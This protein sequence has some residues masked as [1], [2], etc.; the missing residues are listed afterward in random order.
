MSKG[1]G[2][3]ERAIRELFDAHPDLAFITDELAEHCFPEAEAIERKHQVSVLRA[4][5]KVVAPDP[6]WRAWRI[7]GQGRGWVFVNLANVQSYTLG[8]IIADR[9]YIY[10]S[11]KRALR[12]AGIWVRRGPGIRA[13]LVKSPYGYIADRS[14]LAE[15]AVNGGD[16]VT[17]RKI[18]NGT[19]AKEVAEHIAYRDGDAGARAVIDAKREE[20]FQAW[21]AVGRGMAK[22]LPSHRRRWKRNTYHARCR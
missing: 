13:K 5:Q 21:L 12:R 14:K 22:A 1:A 8:R 10:R 20:D 17:R 9:S 3:I 18:D 19:W 4:A 7:E 2:R 16:W 11:E 6:D 15:V